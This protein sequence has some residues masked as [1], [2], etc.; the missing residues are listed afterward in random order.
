MATNKNIFFTGTSYHSTY[1]SSD[2]MYN[3]LLNNND[4]KPNDNCLKNGRNY[5]NYGWQ[6]KSWQNEENSSEY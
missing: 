6:Y 4:R 1:E 3:R 5:M 2:Y